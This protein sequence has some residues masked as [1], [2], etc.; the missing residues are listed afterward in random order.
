MQ[1]QDVI[2]A[3]ALGL[4]IAIAAPGAFASTPAK[5]AASPEVVT[6]TVPAP[7][8]QPQTK[9]EVV[10]VAQSPI[11]C[12]V[13]NRERGFAS[14]VERHDATAFADFIDPNAAFNAG[15]RAPVHGRAAIAV[16]WK[17]I[18]EGKQIKLRWSP[19][20]VTIGGDGSL[21]ISRGP[22]WLED[23]R[24]DAKQRY[25]IGEFISTWSKNRDG[26][27]RVL[28]DSGA[29]PMHAAT[30]DEVAQLVAA[31]PKNCQATPR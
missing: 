26:K 5:P 11:E 8:V 19:A 16:D 12:V 14:S 9:V 21:A 25:R 22:S 6:K 2:T 15:T 31:I 1:Y 27:W 18:V 24:P 10:S 20:I 7:Q 4:A 23:L 3:S 30:A 13:W 28:F 29:T 17:E